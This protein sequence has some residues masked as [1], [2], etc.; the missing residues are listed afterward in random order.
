M[1]RCAL[2]DCGA[3]GIISWRP[4]LEVADVPS[5]K[6]RVGNVREAP[7]ERRV[8]VGEQQPAIRHEGVSMSAAHLCDQ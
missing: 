1:L 4:G 2:N 6:A 8:L 5:A 7:R 3:E